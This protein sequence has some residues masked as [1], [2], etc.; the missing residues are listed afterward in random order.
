MSEIRFVAPPLPH[1]I[2]SGEDS[3][4]PG[5]SHPARRDI[6]VFDLLIVA[7]GCLYVAEEQS[8]FDVAAGQYLLLRPDR[9]HRS[10]RP[11]STET[12]FFWVHLHT[13]GAWSETAESVEPH[14]VTTDDPFIR[15]HQFAFQLPRFGSIVQPDSVYSLLRQLN[16]LLDEPSALDRLKQ[17]NLF[18]DMLLTLLQGA[19]M[20]PPANPRLAIAEQAASYLRQHY[21]EPISYGDL[22]QAVHFHPNYISRCMR[23][24]FGC[25]PLSYLT[26]YRIEQAKLRLIHT[27]EPVGSIAE[28]AGFASFPF[29]VRTFAKHTG[30]RPRE[31]RRKHR[32]IGDR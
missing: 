9:A 4:M 29:F 14:A 7:K 20:Q 15:I 6:G 27:D 30:C 1:Y 8:S 18:Q 17:Q 5:R 32:T 12:H 25:T 26:R 13:L 19:V 10:Y 23:S 21:R 24:V 28:E 16:Q 3:Y 22:A 31:F 11:C 2:F